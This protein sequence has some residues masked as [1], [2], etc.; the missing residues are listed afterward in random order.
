MDEIREKDEADSVC[1][2]VGAPLKPTVSA[3]G[4]KILY[5]ISKLV[6]DVNGIIFALN[7]LEEAMRPRLTDASDRL[8]GFFTNNKAKIKMK[9]KEKTYE[10]ELPGELSSELM[11]IVKNKSTVDT[12][13][14]SLKKPPRCSRWVTRR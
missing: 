13:H 7:S 12:G 8:V 4:E 10:M 11:E 3:P 6:T 1:P 2:D 9:K 14:T 5:A